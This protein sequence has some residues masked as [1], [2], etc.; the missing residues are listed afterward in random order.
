MVEQPAERNKVICMCSKQDNNCSSGGFLC[1]CRRRASEGCARGKAA[2]NKT[3]MPCV[4]AGRLSF[5]RK[6]TKMGNTL[7]MR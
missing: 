3:H 2:G 1:Q 5:Q 7:H 4:P 6:R